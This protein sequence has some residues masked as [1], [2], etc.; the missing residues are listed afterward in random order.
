MSTGVSRVFGLGQC[1]LDHVGK[2]DRYPPPDVKCEIFETVIQGGGPT[3]TAL[4]ALSRW[5]IPCYFAGVVG[6]DLFGGMIETSLREEG[7]NTEGLVIRPTR[8]RPSTP[9]AAG[10]F[11]MPVLSMVWSGGGRR[12][13]VWT[14]APGRRHRSACNWAAGP[15]FRHSPH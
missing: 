14:W 10:M 1:S 12:R 7:V 9:P 3:A 5:G 13:K 11:F 6:D 2:I 8:C 4:A 15:G